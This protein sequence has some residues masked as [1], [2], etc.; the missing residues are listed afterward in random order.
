MLDQRHAAM[1]SL[2]PMVVTGPIDAVIH[3]VVLGI[4]LTVI[5]GIPITVTIVVVIVSIVVVIV[6]IVVAI[7]TTKADNDTAGVCRRSGGSTS[8]GDHRRKN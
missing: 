2:M 3:V 7:T 6:S 8:D 5:V 1:V 4:A